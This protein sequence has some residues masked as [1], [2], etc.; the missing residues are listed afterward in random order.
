D[1][2]HQQYDLLERA[3]MNGK[4]ITAFRRGTEYVVVPTR[5]RMISGREAVDATHPT[6]GDEITL[7]L[8]EMDSFEI[9]R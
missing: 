6:T 4:R 2:N 9:V 8:D 7:Y 3:I 1:W 5:L